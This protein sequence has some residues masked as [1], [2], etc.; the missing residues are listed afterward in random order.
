MVCLLGQRMYMTG[1]DIFYILA[2]ISSKSILSQTNR[3]S[4]LLFNDDNEFGKEMLI[5]RLFLN[6]V[7]VSSA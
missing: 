2:D 6:K 5:Y 4:L 7:I 1:M 3:K